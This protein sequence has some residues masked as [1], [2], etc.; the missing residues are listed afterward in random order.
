MK[1]HQV[2]VYVPSHDRVQPPAEPAGLPERYARAV[3]L[4]LFSRSSVQDSA[5]RGGLHYDVHYL[6][7]TT[8]PLNRIDANRGK[9]LPTTYLRSVE[10]SGIFEP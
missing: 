3:E 6:K 9:F 5:L 2:I 1:C 7:V 4:T 8:C 10:V